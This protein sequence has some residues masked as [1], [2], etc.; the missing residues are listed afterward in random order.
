MIRSNLNSEFMRFI[1]RS[2][3]AFLIL[4]VIAYQPLSLGQTQ[5]KLLPADGD[6][7]DG[8]GTFVAI[9]ETTAIIGTPFDEDNGS[10]SGSAYLFDTTTGKQTFK[11]LAS[12]GGVTD[13]FGFSVSISGNTA[14]VGALN[15]DD[16]GF[17]SG[18]AYLF[19]TVSGM[20]TFKLLAADGDAEDAFGW[21]V[22]I[23][24]TTAIVGAYMDDDNG[25]DSGSA[26]LFDTTTGKQIAKLLPTDGATTDEFGYSVAISG[27]TAIVGAEFDDDNGSASGSAYLFDTTTGTQIAKL[28]ANDGEIGDN[29][30]HSVAIS[31]TTALVGAYLDNDNGINAGSAYLFDTITGTQITKLLPTDGT[32]SDWFGRSV[33][34]SGATALVGAIFGGDNGISYGA[35]YRFDTTTG[36]QIDKLLPK[37]GRFADGFGISVAINGSTGVVGV[38]GD[39]YNGSGAGAAYLYHFEVIACL[40]LDVQN[41]VAGQRAQFTITGGTPGARGVTLYGLNK[42]KTIANNMAGYCATIGIKDVIIIGGI[43]GLNRVFN[44]NGEITFNQTVPDNATGVTV[45]FQSA[46]QGTCPD[47]CVSNLVEQIIQ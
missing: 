3:P 45:F 42:G 29:F 4:L 26:Y 15:D 19:D 25:R 37:D 9:S 21:S 44:A 7:G 39:D 2:I 6:S 27:T 32:S 13:E 22:A 16:N 23:S 36:M 31:G 41:L 46:E 8:F 28:L 17:R 30:G 43:R 24:G 35:A 5:M 33:S 14:I 18:S 47:E 40:S 12:D 10:L 38:Q 34:I 20:Q 1:R 11:L